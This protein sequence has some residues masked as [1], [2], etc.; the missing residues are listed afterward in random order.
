M[1][2][3]F[4]IGVID[5]VEKKI[6]IVFAEGSQSAVENNIRE[7]TGLSQAALTK[8]FRFT[9]PYQTAGGAKKAIPKKYAGWS[10]VD[11]L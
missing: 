9:S 7:T 5:T 8:R 1:K 6:V 3:T 4:Y 11:E 2:D 10:F